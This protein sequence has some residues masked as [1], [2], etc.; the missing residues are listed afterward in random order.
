V[1]PK[2]NRAQSIVRKQRAHCGKSKKKYGNDSGELHR[3]KTEGIDDRMGEGRGGIGRHK[4]SYQG[5]K[6]VFPMRLLENPIIHLL[7]TVR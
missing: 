2:D 5:P 7:H 3:N 4:S 1:L 6:S